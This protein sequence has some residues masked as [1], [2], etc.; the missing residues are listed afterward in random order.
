LI[1]EIRNFNFD[2]SNKMKKTTRRDALKKLA[3]GTLAAGSI[4]G[5][6]SYNSLHKENFALKP[7]SP[8]YLILKQLN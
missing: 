8:L 7:H 4:S 2:C 6:S 1:N 5:L 3:A